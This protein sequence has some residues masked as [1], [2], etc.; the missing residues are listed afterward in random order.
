MLDQ[1]V[2]A[3]LAWCILY[4]IEVTHCWK[5]LPSIAPEHLLPTSQRRTIHSDIVLENAVREFVVRG[6]SIY[7]LTIWYLYNDVGSAFTVF[8]EVRYA[9][10]LEF[11]FCRIV[12]IW[13]KAI[14]NEWNDDVVVQCYSIGKR[15]T[16]IYSKYLLRICQCTILAQNIIRKKKILWSTY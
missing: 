5:H 9:T 14:A 1:T 12:L 4:H 10:C 16:F 11:Q 3:G 7:L 15:S 8:V 2:G 6:L 13:A